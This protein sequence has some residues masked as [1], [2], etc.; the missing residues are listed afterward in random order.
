M[1]LGILIGFLYN[2]FCKKN[3]RKNQVGPDDD[4]APT[5]NNSAMPQ[6]SDIDDPRGS[7]DGKKPKELKSDDEQVRIPIDT[8]RG[9]VNQVTTEL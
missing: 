3:Q 2:C 5:E 9:L 1:F 7:V 8:E 4:R 6:D